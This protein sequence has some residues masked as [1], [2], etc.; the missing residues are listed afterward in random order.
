[1]KLYEINENILACVD[2]ETG[3]IIEPKKLNDLQIAKN[4]KFENLALWYN[5]LISEAEALK[6]EKE[7][8]AAREKV[9][10]NR[11][12][13]I[14]NYLSFALQGEDFKTTKC[15]VSFRKSEK[16]IVDDIGE[17]PEE[18]LTIAEPKANLTEIKKAIKNGEEIKGAHIE[19]THNIQIK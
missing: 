14:K 13:S 6:A 1:M 3:E 4:A 18:Y 8:F 10:K 12:E 2:S 7:A 17:L 11:A 5:D 19:E 16:T 9:A 15:V